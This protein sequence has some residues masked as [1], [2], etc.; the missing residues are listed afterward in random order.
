MQ[1]ARAPLEGCGSPVTQL[2]LSLF[3]GVGLL[4]RA[5]EEE[6]FTIVR[7]PDVLWGGDVRSFHPGRMPAPGQ[8]VRTQAVLSAREAVPVALGGSG[9]RKPGARVPA[10]VGSHSGSKWRPRHGHLV[11]Y[12]WEE[13]LRLQ[14]L[15]PDFLEK[16]FTPF[17]EEG[18]RKTVAN[19]VPIQLGRAI[20]KA[21]RQ[22]LG[23][24]GEATA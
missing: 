16:K 3:S 23:L 8:R 14:G 1:I 20:A 13:M 19:G 12:R 24:P 2:V 9:K 21:V 18:R 10:V 11:V 22:A 6:W 5:F 4:D 7:G 17:T 15:P